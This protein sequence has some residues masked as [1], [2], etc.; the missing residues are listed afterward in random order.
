MQ[1]QEPIFEA[2]VETPV[3]RIKITADDER[4]L[5]IDFTGEAHASCGNALCE[6]AV[7]ELREYFS[8]KRKTFDLPLKKAPSAFAQRVYDEA[9]KIPFGETASYGELARAAGSPGAARAV[10]TALSK[11]P[12]I[13]VVP[14]HRVIRQNGEPGRYTGGDEKKIALLAFEGA[15]S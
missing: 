5:S 9:M 12:H 1:I 2:F 4:I 6:R 11:N 10:G 3:G 15:V 14:C 8:G 7:R 13:I